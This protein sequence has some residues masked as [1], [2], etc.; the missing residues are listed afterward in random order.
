ML[1]V[2]GKSGAI[3]LDLLGRVSGEVYRKIPVYKNGLNIKTIQN[4]SLN[5]LNIQTIFITDVVSPI[6]K[7]L[8]TKR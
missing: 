4:A 6:P 5:G 3:L 2:T 1:Y 7:Y 8:S